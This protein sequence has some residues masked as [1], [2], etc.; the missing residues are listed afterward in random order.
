[1]L[2]RSFRKG[3]QKLYNTAVHHPLQTWEW[4][5]FRK[6]TNVVVERLGF[7]ENEK[8]QQSLQVTFHPLPIIGKTAG[9]LP[10][11]FMPNENQIA[12]LK[13]LGKEQNALFIKLEPNVSQPAET[14]VS[15]H[16]EIRKF[17]QTHGCQPGKPL[18]TKHTFELDLQ[19]SEEELFAKLS[20]KT[21]YNVRLA[22]KKGVQIFENSSDEGLETYIEIL[23]ETTTRQGFYAHTPDYFR[24]MWQELKDSGMMKIF[25]AV[26]EEKVLVSWI[27]FLFDGVL[28]YPYGASRRENRD[29]MASNLM[30][31]E[32]IRFGKKENCKS[33][34]MWGSLGP[35][36]D[37]KN[38]WFGFHRFKKGYGGQLREFI[39]TYD[40]VL[41]PTMY[42]L[43]RK[44]DKLRWKFLRL[45]KKIGL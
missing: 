41:D 28:Y 11:G 29:V 39:G 37:P 40:L 13:R 45:R 42:P 15:G 16:S 4:G 17:L 21:R 7:F 10:K 34:D 8:L 22:S 5:E 6:K 43:F 25:N 30:M 35:K 31:W 14:A 38:P 24:N 27:V 9:Y 23:K 20:N 3:E 12:A 44:V 2:I 19:R 36:P 32:M 26:Y 18:F 1:M 33:F